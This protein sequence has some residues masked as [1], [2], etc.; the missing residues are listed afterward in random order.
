MLLSQ[1]LFQVSYAL[2][3]RITGDGVGRVQ[4]GV[5]IPEPMDEGMV[6]NM[7]AN[8]T[9][10]IDTR[11]DSGGGRREGTREGGD[12]VM[13][14]VS[15]GV[16]V[17]DAGM[18]ESRKEESAE[19]V[20]G[21]EGLPDAPNGGSTGKD[22]GTNDV[23][24]NEVLAGAKVQGTA[25]DK[26]VDGGDAFLRDGELEE[27]ALQTDLLEKNEHLIAIDDKLKFFIAEVAR[28]TSELDESAELL[29]ECQMNCAHLE[30]RLHEAREEARTNL[31]AADRR[32]AEY[33]ALRITSVRL[34][35]LME[36]LRSCITAPAGNP[37]SFAESLRALAVS[38]S[39]ANVNDGSE[40][41]EFR[42]AIRVLADRVG[43][44]VQ[45]RGELLERCT[46]AETNQA[47]LKKDLE[48]QA[49]LLKNLYSKR[50][51]DKQASKEKICFTRFEI[52]GL[53][54]FLQNA[55]GHFEA[56]NH[57]RPH[58]YLS[59]ES[60]ALFQEQGLP[61]GS[62]YVVGQIVH[63]DR[64][65]VIPAPPPPPL[66]AGSSDGSVQGTELGAG[67]MLTPARA[68]ASHNP[69]GLPL[70]TDYYIV[71]VAMVPDL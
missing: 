13:S 53:A 46:I 23:E 7:Q 20:D 37:S 67:T 25:L 52:H 45:Q 69:Y 51:F 28:L 68:K 8:S 64:K 40:D 26:N 65:V 50:K 57:N 5:G 36:R 35:G 55:N 59:G 15:G 48:N 22:Q 66:L 16:S 70:G 54:V 1:G 31:C 21:N 49:E 6:S 29:N 34:R 63:I 39:S 2:L 32:A 61:S 56:I 14:D 71:T 27:S 42:N 30:N 3:V 11:T 12:E 38:L 18:V 41:G 47:H 17:T 33:S 58:Y 60:I 44:L 24:L 19:G 10:S 4:R 9:A 62:P 43:N